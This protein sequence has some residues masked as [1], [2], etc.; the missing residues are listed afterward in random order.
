[1][2][3]KREVRAVRPIPKSPTGI[4]GFDDITGGGL[5]KGRTSL[6]YGSAG[7][8]KS[9]FSMEYLFRG[10]TEFGEAGVLMAFEE[11]KEKIQANAAALGFDLQ[12]LVDEKKLVVDYVHVERSEIEETGEYD[13]GGLFARLE[14]HV[15][16][17]RAKRVV[18]DTLEVL[19]AGLKNQGIIRSELRRLFRWLE[20]HHLS[21]VIT[22][23]RG[24][25][26][27]TRHGL[28][29]YVSDCVVLLDHRVAEEL[30][31]RRLRIVKYRGS[32][33][34]TNEYPFLIDEQGISVVPLSGLSLEHE[35]TR[36]RISTGIPALDVMLGGK[37]YYQ[38]SSILISGTAGTGKSSIAASFAASECARGRSTLLFTLEESPKQ[39]IRNMNSIGI[40]LE[41]W[42]RK[43]LLNLQAS[44]P[45]V[46]GLE[47]HLV[48]L[49]KMIEEMDAKAVIIDPVTALLAAGNPGETRSLL[50]RLI[51]LLK[52]KGITA[53]LTSLTED[54]VPLES[55][56]VGISSLIDTW[57]TLD[58]TRS[59]GERNR[60][61]QIVKS[62][63]MNHSNQVREFLLS[64][65]GLQLED[66]Y[67]GS[68]GVL[69]GSARLAQ[70]ALDRT[71]ESRRQYDLERQE[72]GL[73]VEE[74]VLRGQISAI[75]EKLRIVTGDRHRLTRLDHEREARANE[76]LRRM[77]E[78]RRA[79]LPRRREEPSNGR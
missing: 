71:E 19:F 68:R 67:L 25:G 17:V 7:C 65:E 70:E 75:Q 41:R 51:D 30:S 69:T 22:A 36:S 49:H 43:G 57:I 9:M 1:M 14:H 13:L 74:N 23:E 34:G 52:T 18:L 62:R 45:S 50:V 60:V 54:G 40:D 5:P 16:T 29:E 76:D 26:Q 15:K 2:S 46:Y 35:A 20:E 72:I 79:A 28:E 31:T 37:G 12:K 55:S 61:L 56:E 27:L 78:S 53:I 63:G 64:D 24:E 39:V 8:G 77:A 73:Q 4:R 32:G 10:A 38:G 66:V 33:H 44:R 3:P 58:H 47:M 21:A 11:T 48:H 59:G 6:V 42:V